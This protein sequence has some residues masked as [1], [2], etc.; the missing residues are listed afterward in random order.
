MA[1]NVFIQTLHDSQAKTVIKVVGVYPAANA[2]ANIIIAQANTF[3]GA[4]TS[5]TYCPIS[6]TSMQYV[7][8]VGAGSV[9]LQWVSTVNTNST[10]MQFGASS[11]N[12][13]PWW[14]EYDGSKAATLVN[15]ANTPSGDLNLYIASMAANDFFNFVIVFNKETVYG[16]PGVGAW[17]NQYSA[18]QSQGYVG[19]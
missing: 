13:P 5:K 14:G 16:G 12:S 7:V 19:D 9:A 2:A 4:N 1:A 11:V 17:A 15:N 3:F 8:G 6:I 10:I 18:Y